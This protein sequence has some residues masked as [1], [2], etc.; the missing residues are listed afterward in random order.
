MQRARLAVDIGGTFTDLALEVGGRRVTAKVL[1][2]PTQPERGVLD[3]VGVIL[4]QAGLGPDDVGIL[5]HGTTL[6]TN[7][8]HRAQGG[9]DGADHDGGVPRRS[10]ARQ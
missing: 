1:T 8:D 4:Q 10:R 2:T 7:S 5:V 6:A 9:D 3:G